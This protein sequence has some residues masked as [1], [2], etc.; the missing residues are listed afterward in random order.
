MTDPVFVFGSNLLGIHG[1]GAAKTARDQYGAVLGQ[2][3]GYF[4]NSYAIPTKATP[5]KTLPL[6]VIR[7]YVLD[8]VAFAKEHPELTFQVTRVGC[9][10]AG[11]KDHQIG[12]MFHHAPDNC[13]LPDEWV[14]MRELPESQ[15]LW[16][17]LIHL[18]FVINDYYVA[19]IPGWNPH[20][21]VRIP[22]S[23]IPEDM[24]EDEFVLA[25]VNIGAETK[26]ELRF[27]HFEK[28]PTP[29]EVDTA[30]GKLGL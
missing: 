3:V 26:E 24:R 19:N 17:A 23:T 9:G 1:H 10:L 25:Y 16:R 20:V 27:E 28:A 4:G 12:P 8:F 13:Q 29:E 15:R 30:M 14:K 6:H 11:Y 2:G 22:V 18:H 5:Y 21:P 7:G